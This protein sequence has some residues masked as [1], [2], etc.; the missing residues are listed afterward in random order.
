MNRSKRIL[1]ITVLSVELSRNSNTNRRRNYESKQS[2]RTTYA[3]MLPKSSVTK[4]CLHY[5][6]NSQT[7]G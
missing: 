2:V 7:S 3:F 5:R 1:R 4:Q 6:V